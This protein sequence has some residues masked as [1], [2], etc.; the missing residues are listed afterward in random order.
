MHAHSLRCC[1]EQQCDPLDAHATNIINF[2]AEGRSLH[3]WVPNTLAS[4]R[5]AIL[6]MFPDLSEGHGGSHI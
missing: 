1:H 3:N 6:D 4:Y 5:S 2:L